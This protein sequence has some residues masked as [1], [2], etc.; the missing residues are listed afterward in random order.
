MSDKDPVDGRRPLEARLWGEARFAHRGVAVEPTS[1]KSVA[2]LAYLAAAP[3]PSSRE[4]LAALLWGPGRLANVRQALYT[5]RSL[6]GAEEWLD[7]GAA[8]VNVLAVVD[9]VE[10]TAAA[11][12]ELPAL[13]ERL[14]GNE[15]MAGFGDRLPEPYLEWLAH[16]R[17]RCAAA[18]ARA[19][20]AKAAEL[21]GEGHPREALALA[22]RAQELEPYG[23]EAQRAVMRLAYLA[24][25]PERALASYATFSARLETELGSRPSAETARLASRI[26]RR[27][28]LSARPALASLDEQE[29]R[30]LRALAL[31]RGGLRVDG[32]ARVLERPAFELTADLA[33]LADRGLVDADLRLAPDLVGPVL[34]GVPAPLKRLLHERSVAVM[35]D[36]PEADQGVLARHLLAVGELAE[37]AR[38]AFGAARAAL[39]RGQTDAASDLLYLTLWAAAEEP[40]LRLD[41]LFQLEGVAAQ[42]ADLAAQEALLQEAERL[43]WELQ[44]DVALAEA[45]VR[46]ARLLLARSQVGEALESALVALE[47]ALRIADDTLVARAR[48][49]LGAAHFYAGDLDGAEAA[50][51]SCLV[52]GSEVERYRAHNNLGSINAL[53]GRL[54]ESYHHFDQAL[55]LARRNS[56]HL[57]VSATLNNVAASA[58]RFGDYPRAERYFKE[59]M[60]LARRRGAAAREAEMLVNLA[61]VY[62]RQGQLGPAWNT[63]AEVEELVDELADRR[64][65]MRV[66][67]QRGELMRLC[68]DLAGAEAALTTA[69]L[70]AEEVGDE[71]KRRG[72]HAQLATVRARRDPTSAPETARAIADLET[73]RLTDVAPWL[74]LELAL[75]T[76]ELSFGLAQLASVP[77][78]GLKSAHQRLVRDVATMRLG[79]LAEA[80]EAVRAEAMAARARTV[81]AGL[82]PPGPAGAAP[83]GPVVR[84]VERPKARYLASVLAGG[85]R[86]RAV[87]AGGG[88]APTPTAGVAEDVLEELREQGAG[89]PRRLAEALLR[90]PAAWLPP[91]REG[92]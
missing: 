48:N 53:R 19:Y 55:T 51:A 14:E 69:L 40:R 2:L 23:E 72:L 75:W 63:I 29:L 7:A 83:P 60:V 77:E 35:R 49:A 68:G 91:P 92:L 31:A 27:E 89:L 25:D 76:Q 18:A 6:P 86:W 37:A 9:V 3:G 8:T 34:A 81:A 26:E 21:E 28:P 78:A 38:R 46:R 43:A 52:S 24:G 74:R 90:T 67:E 57:D 41:A 44:S 73:A 61:V 45:N 87:E 59:G 56:R 16:E 70:L 79:L 20:A 42:D 10:L 64:L 1:Q 22:L 54:G 11:R 85:P 82:V 62:A 50:F 17:E 4:E 39:E 32:L 30:T 15:F 5:L 80:D 12:E 47:I 84:I 36:D 65:A 88:G 66:A 58:E 13:A 33:R 71:R